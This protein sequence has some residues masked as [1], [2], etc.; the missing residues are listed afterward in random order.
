MQRIRNTKA[1]FNYELLDSIEAGL[2]LSGAEVKS[3]RAGHVSLNES[4]IVIE[5]GELY[6]AKC[7]I[8]PYQLKNQAAY[9]PYQKR[10]VLVSQKQLR[11]FAQKKQEAG[12]TLIPISLY[13]KGRLI[14][15]EVALAR[16]KKKH[17]KRETLKRRDAEREIS[18]M[19][20]G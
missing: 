13:A 9:D 10:K 19:M 14:K 2:V 6:L 5:N 1:G 16:G 18:R 15:L 8:A 17:D 3:V 11:E 12:L 20:R 4:F 7:H